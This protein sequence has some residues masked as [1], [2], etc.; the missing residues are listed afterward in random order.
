MV[1]SMVGIPLSKDTH[2]KGMGS[3][4]ATPLREAML[5]PDTLPLAI[6]L[7]GTQP[8]SMVLMV[9]LKVALM[10]LGDLVLAVLWLELQHWQVPMVCTKLDPVPMVAN[11]DPMVV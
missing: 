10:A 7:L 8:R 3:R 2:P 1:D 6:L 4:K 5:R 11:T 9:A